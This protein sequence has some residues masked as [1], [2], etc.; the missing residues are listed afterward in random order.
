MVSTWEAKFF[1]MGDAV[2]ADETGANRKHEI[3]PE[4]S[5]INIEFTALSTAVLTDEIWTIPDTNTGE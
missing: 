4:Q 3:A 2:D 5:D 1:A